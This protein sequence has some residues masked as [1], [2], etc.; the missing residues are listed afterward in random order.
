MNHQGLSQY[1]TAHYNKLLGKTSLMMTRNLGNSKAEAPLLPGPSKA[2]CSPAPIPASTISS[3][4]SEGPGIASTEGENTTLDWEE[5][6]TLRRSLPLTAFS[7]RLSTWPLMFQSQF[8]LCFHVMSHLQSF[9][10]LCQNSF[11]KYVW[12]SVT[13]GESAPGPLLHPSDISTCRSH[14]RPAW[15]CNNFNFFF[16]D[17]PQLWRQLSFVLVTQTP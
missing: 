3:R 11:L 5:T 1:F 12:I 7:L 17:S 13:L 10:L 2:P 16:L 6:R 9:E 14:R 15:P 4:H 8:K